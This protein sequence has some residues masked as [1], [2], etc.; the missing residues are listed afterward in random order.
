MN[1]KTVDLADFSLASK[2]TGR[3][4]KSL[5]SAGVEYDDARQVAAIA[6]WQASQKPKT[7]LRFKG[8][9]ANWAISNLI[10]HVNAVSRLDVPLDLLSDTGD[11][12]Q[13]PDKAV[14]NEERLTMADELQTIGSALKSYPTKR[15]VHIYI[16]FAIQDCKGSDIVKRYGLSNSR[17]SR[18]VKKVRQY[19]RIEYERLHPAC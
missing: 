3:W 16:S 18:I 13:L 10:R 9:S 14:S 6:I 19:L 5:R 7:N 1:T 12:D 11:L 17:I 8:Q 4:Y 2:I 15:D